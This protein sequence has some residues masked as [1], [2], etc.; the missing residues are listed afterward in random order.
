MIKLGVNID[1]IATIRNAR[2]EDQ[3]D[4]IKAAK[5]VS[6]C[7][8]D[9]ITIHAFLR[10][11]SAVIARR[12]SAPSGLFIASAFVAAYTYTCKYTYTYTYTQE[13]WYHR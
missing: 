6:Q 12:G 13:L 4:I 1:H 10:A 5:F 9:I 11:F 8:A 2:G 7:G 3:P